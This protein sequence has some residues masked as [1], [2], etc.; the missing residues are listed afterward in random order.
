MD[1]Q[2]FLQMLQGHPNSLSS[3]LIFSGLLRDYFP[4]ERML[5]NLMI[6]LFKMGIHTEIDRNL[7]V[8]NVFAYRFV[9]R[10]VDDYGV[11]RENA[12]NAVRLFCKCYGKGILNKS[13]DW[14]SKPK[15]LQAQSVQTSVARPTSPSNMA[16]SYYAGMEID[17]PCGRCKTETLHRVL[18]ITDGVPET[19]ICATCNSTHKF[20][21]KRVSTESASAGRPSN[22]TL[23]ATKRSVSS[24]SGS[25]LVSSW[26]ILF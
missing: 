18:S 25:L 14:E 10:L 26:I 20:K 11:I 23:A 17:A 24:S 3:S 8:T 22:S 7:E 16:K 4:Q 15:M 6:A 5:V 19:L 13:C 1:E 2:R 9:K 12:D 21:S